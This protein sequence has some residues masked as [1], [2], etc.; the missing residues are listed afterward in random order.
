VQ[1]NNLV[2][3]AIGYNKDRG[4]SINVVNAAF[5]ESIPLEEKPLPEKALS[6]M[7]SHAIDVLKMLVIGI[8]TL[9]LLFFVIRPLMKDLN[10]SREEARTMEL[11]LGE[12]GGGGMFALDAGAGE[13][14]E[15]EQ[16]KMSAFADLLQQA[17]ELAKNDPRMVA[18]ILREWMS[19]QDDAGNPNKIS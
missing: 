17:K 10:R 6:Y 14:S 16:N 18:T 12:A 11:D 15:E 5:A 4:D 7:Q 19:S 2:R 13:E 9:Y 1:I 3:E 8:A